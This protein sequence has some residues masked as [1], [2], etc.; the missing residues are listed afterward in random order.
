MVDVIA[1]RYYCTSG[2]E[3]VADC[4][5]GGWHDTGKVPGGTVG[6]AEGLFDYCC[7]SVD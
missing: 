4:G 2:N 1:V 5:T 3:C 6:Q 7:L